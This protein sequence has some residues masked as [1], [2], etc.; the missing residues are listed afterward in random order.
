[1]N[2]ILALSY[3]SLGLAL[4]PSLSTLGH[5]E[6][7]SEPSSEIN[8]MSLEDLMNVKISGATREKKAIQSTPAIV[9]VVT[10]EEIKNMGARDLIDV[11][12]LVPG[13]SLATD[14]QGTV[15]I[16]VRGMW[17][18]EGKVLL[19]IDGEEMNEISFN[20]LQMGNHFPVDSISRLEVI[21]GPGSAAHG[22]YAELAV[23]N[24]IT[25]G[26]SELDGFVINGTYG[27][28]SQ[29]FA[30]RYLGFGYAKKFGEWNVSGYGFIG[31]GNRSER[32]F[33]DNLGDTFNLKGNSNLNPAFVNLGLSNDRWIFR[34]I[35]DHFNTTDK[36][37]YGTNAPLAVRNNFESILLGAKYTAPVSQTVSLSPEIHLKQNIPWNSTNPESVTVPGLF[38]DVKAQ[39]IKGQLSLRA[40]L[41]PQLIFHLGG[42]GAMQRAHD[43]TERTFPN[44]RNEI[45]YYSHAAFTEVDWTPEFA[46]LTFGGRYQSQNSGGQA[47]VPRFSAVKQIG[48]F[49]TK[50][51]YSWGF[52]APGIENLRANSSLKPETT[53][54][55]ETEIGYRLSQTMFT[56]LNAYTISLTDPIIYGYSSGAETYENSS[57]TGTYGLE[58]DYKIRPSWGYID[59]N[60]SYFHTK[61]Q[62][63]IDYQVP[64]HPDSLLGM[65]NHKV[66]LNV[67][68]KLFDDHTRLNTNVTFLSRR[69]GFDYDAGSATGLSVR[70]FNPT[71]LTNVFLER[72]DL[73]TPGLSAGIGVYNLL[74][75]DFRFIQPYDGGHPPVPGP[76]RDWVLKIG[77]QVKL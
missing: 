66:S 51:I 55:A 27:Q 18:H 22:G 77:Y 38:Y 61:A 26:A 47:F 7:P 40:E 72:T 13:L 24:I 69:F 15:G 42:E 19:L 44:S 25:K 32:D 48:D 37:A 35:Y 21:R 74:D 60:Y 76:S 46:N 6:V 52:R 71:A 31:Q 57:E 23:I 11:L 67:N 10:A 68:F 58:W 43:F 56:T 9:T 59:L 5:C 29:T 41:N 2:P 33:T 16:A 49:H 34:L 73:F 8:S 4:L 65:A 14:T 75:Q 12:N 20:T 39:E 1:M 63:P 64:D 54:V 50:L 53:K 3:V 28:M 45:S 36:T 62:E 17:A 30:Q 70:S